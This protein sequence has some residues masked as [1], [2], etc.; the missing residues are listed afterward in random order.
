MPRV[1][2][3]GIVMVAFLVFVAMF[4][5]QT[6]EGFITHEIVGNIFQ[7]NLAVIM[8]PIQLFTGQLTLLEGEGVFVGWI[9]EI[10]YIVSALEHNRWASAVKSGNS[11]M[12]GL[13]EVGIIAATA[14][15][16]WTDYNYFP[17]NML[18]KVIISALIFFV[19]YYFGHGLNF[20][21]ANTAKA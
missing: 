1:K 6:T 13:F 16:G 7:P 4:Q 17:G 12:A 2:F 5:I 19:S 3:T 20:F 14:F 15:N 9:V 8:Q 11:R 18:T 21:S 10:I